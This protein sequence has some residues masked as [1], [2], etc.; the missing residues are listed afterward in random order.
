MR[1]VA[2]ISMFENLQADANQNMGVDCEMSVFNGKYDR[3]FSDL[4]NTLE[5]RQRNYPNGPVSPRWLLEELMHS[6]ATQIAKEMMPDFESVYMDHVKS[7]LE[8]Y[9]KWRITQD[10]A[11]ELGLSLADVLDSGLRNQ[12]ARELQK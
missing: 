3:A 12:V 8:E 10:R 4:A 7:F 6:V 2:D 11:S 1:K 9:N 5:Y